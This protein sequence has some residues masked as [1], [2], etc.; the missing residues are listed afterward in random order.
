MQLWSRVRRLGLVIGALA[1]ITT[2]VGAT[3]VLSAPAP[4]SAKPAP[5]VTLYNSAQGKFSTGNVAGG[6]AD[7]AAL[8]RIAPKDSQALALQ[9]IWAD[10]AY[11]FPTKAAA[12]ARLNAVSPATARGVGGVFGAIGAG[13][14]TVPN[15]L[16]GI[17]GPR[18]AIVA[19]G[20]GLLPNGTMRP[21]LVERL[22]KTWVQAL[23]APASPVIVTGG[24][25]QNG[26]TEAAAMKRWLVGRGIPASRIVA[27]TRA[28]STV[29]NALNSAAIMKSRGWGNAIIVSS[30]N[31]LR[32]A[33]AD[34]IVAG[35]P[36]VGTTTQFNGWTSE[37]LP[38]TRDA[39]RGIY[40][41]VTRTFG[42]PAGR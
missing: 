19:L 5:S 12:L 7:L 38:P 15:P 4:A 8:V 27:E 23:I 31:H 37:I 40:L 36:V 13:I 33:V 29:A 9:A 20:Y 35:V 3:Q 24:A 32:R 21:E 25:P 42:L 22:T 16:P 30:A 18:T 17:I 34:F 6:L 39:Q 11:D 41:D 28:G 10:Y 2:G 14:A 1:V 26:V